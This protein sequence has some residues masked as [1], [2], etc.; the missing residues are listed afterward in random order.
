MDTEFLKSAAQT[1]SPD[2][3]A[4]TLKTAITDLPKD[5]S[6]R[7]KFA[8]AAMDIAQAVFKTVHKELDELTSDERSIGSKLQPR[9]TTAR[10]YN[11]GQ[12]FET[13]HSLSGAGTSRRDTAEEGAYKVHQEL[14]ILVE[15]HSRWLYQFKLNNAI[16][17]NHPEIIL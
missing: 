1:Q 15:T 17:R 11:V 13:V 2:D 16:A 6:L 8:E 10:L 7:T 3:F 12:L 5:E 9:A 14:A 4:K